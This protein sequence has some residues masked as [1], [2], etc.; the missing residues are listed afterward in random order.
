LAIFTTALCEVVLSPDAG[1]AIE[2][3]MRVRR[4]EASTAFWPA[5]PIVMVSVEATTPPWSGAV[6]L[7]VMFTGRFLE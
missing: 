5:V 1:L 2:V 7:V 6:E 4:P 3:R